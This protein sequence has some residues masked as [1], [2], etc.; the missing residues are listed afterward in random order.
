MPNMQAVKRLA[1]TFGV[2]HWMEHVVTGS[3]LQTLLCVIVVTHRMYVSPPFGHFPTT[4]RQKPFFLLRTYEKCEAALLGGMKA[5][6]KCIDVKFVALPA[7]IQ[8]AVHESLIKPKQSVE[9][10][11][12]P[13]KN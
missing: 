13:G 11:S 2:Y 3:I 6:I 5:H 7:R 10:S 1:L 4:I 12:I 9:F 8:L